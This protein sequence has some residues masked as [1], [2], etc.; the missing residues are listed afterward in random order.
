MPKLACVLVH[1]YSHDFN[2]SKSCAIE[3][4]GAS[5]VINRQVWRHLIPR[6][7]FDSPR[8]G[9]SWICAHWVAPEGRRDD[10]RGSEQYR[11]ALPEIDAEFGARSNR[12]IRLLQTIKW[13]AH[14]RSSRSV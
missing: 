3:L 7:G 13:V 2:C 4:E 10:G 14:H 6:L 12:L 9:G 5:A 11:K 1:H 8:S